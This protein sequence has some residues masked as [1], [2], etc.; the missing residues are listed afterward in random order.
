MATSQ[1]ILI[2]DDDAN[3]RR[4]MD[5]ILQHA[6]YAVAT[7][8]NVEEIWQALSS[9]KYDLVILDIKM[10]D[11]SGL[12]LL[13][14]M[15]AQQPGTPVAI[16]TAH[17]SPMAAVEAIEKGASNYLLKPINPPQFVAK[18]REILEVQNH[19]EHRKALLAELQLLI[20]RKQDVDLARLD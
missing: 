2:I 1:S 15:I 8:G 17:A 7:A 9:R 16:L 10:P 20:E 6:G 5:L 4:S 19:A 12:D 13:E 18:I 3:L 14:P 11:A